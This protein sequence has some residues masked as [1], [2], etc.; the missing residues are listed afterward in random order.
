MSSALARPFLDPVK[1]SGQWLL[2]YCIRILSLL[3]ILSLTVNKC[4]D[5]DNAKDQ[6]N[7]F[8]RNV[9]SWVTSSATKMLK[10]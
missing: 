4:G 3:V 8:A 10:I 1:T 5:M 6:I 2:S 7:Q 9:Q